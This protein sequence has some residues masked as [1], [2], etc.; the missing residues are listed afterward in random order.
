MET[1]SKYIKTILVF[2]NT[3]IK[4]DSLAKTVA[5]ELKKELTNKE[6]K[7]N[8]ENTKKYEFIDCTKPD[9]ILSYLNED[10]IILDV[11]KRLNEVKLFTNVDDFKDTCTV[12][13]HDFD[14]S[15]FLKILKETGDLKKIK[16]IGIPQSGNIK[17]I[18]QKIIEILKNDTK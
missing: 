12:T 17:E 15:T 14:L 8:S 4:E 18:K 11:V 16:I 1:N 3:D 9:D 5:K 13:A 7:K 2:G 10:F 6:S